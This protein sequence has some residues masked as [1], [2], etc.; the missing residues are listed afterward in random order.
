MVT[1]INPIDFVEWSV[2]VLSV[3]VKRGLLMLIMRLDRLKVLIVRSGLLM[4]TM[5]W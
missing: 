4:L 5:R 3:V 2:M 1:T